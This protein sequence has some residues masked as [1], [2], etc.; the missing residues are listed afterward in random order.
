M[1]IAIET[2]AANAQHYEVPAKFYDLCLGPCKKYSSGLWPTPT[3]TF[4]ESEIIMLDLYCQ[5]AGV[6]DGMHI[7]DLGCGWGS[8]TLH[9]IQKYPNCKITS[10]SNSHSQ[11]D[12]ILNTA[13]E[14]GNNVQNIQVIT[15]NVA[16]DKGALSVVKDNDLVMTVEMFEHMKNYNDLL[17]KVHSFLKPSGHLFV[18]IFTHKD[19][20]YH[21]DK[22]WMSDNFFSGGTMPSDDLLLYFAQDFCVKAHWRVNGTNYEKT[23]NG[24]LHYLDTAWKAG[25]LKPVLAE[26]Y[27]VGQEYKWYVNWRLF[28]LACAELWGLEKGE[29]WIVSHYL[30][31]RR[32]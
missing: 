2:D 28:F 9:L 27:G 1:P 17:K 16:D 5:R 32:G 13:K 22:G 8:L 14:R 25:T 7:V 15:C 21:F 31:Q 20:T 30:F 29:E 4:E 11:R 23:S 19:F 24:W 6:K 3:T 10:I 12:Y 26:A 18:H